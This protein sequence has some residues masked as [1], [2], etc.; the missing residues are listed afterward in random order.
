MTIEVEE[1]TAC[2]KQW[3]CGH[4]R[5]KGPLAFFFIDVSRTLS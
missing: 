4:R 2:I 5:P 1:N 3:H